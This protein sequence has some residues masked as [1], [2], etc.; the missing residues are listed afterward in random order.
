[1]STCT[2]AYTYT[3][4]YTCSSPRPRT[5]YGRAHGSECTR[6]GARASTGGARLHPNSSAKK[7]EQHERVGR[8]G[9]GNASED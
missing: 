3:Y 6:S 1:M 7:A 9:P 4:T 8:R 5:L 2:Y